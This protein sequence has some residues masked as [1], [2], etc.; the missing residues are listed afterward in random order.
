MAA[1]ARTG[2]QLSYLDL[3]TP[4]IR[5]LGLTVRRVWSPDTLGPCLPSAPPLLHRRFADYGGAANPEPHPY[6]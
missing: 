6:L 3:T 1:F 4:D 5:R 2:K